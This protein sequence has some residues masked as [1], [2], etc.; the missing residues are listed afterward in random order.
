[1]IPDLTVLWVV[2]FVLTLAGVVKRLL[3][4][5]VLRVMRERDRVVASAR[6]LAE[7]AAGKAESATAEAS[8]TVRAARAEVY[9]QMDEKR[10]LALT[11][12][13]E[14]LDAARRDAEAGIGEARS[15]LEAQAERARHQLTEQADALGAAAVE[16]ILGRKTS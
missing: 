9:R 11:Q 5:P 12:H 2:L 10:R 15:R 1:M 7:S 14:V 3:F 6:E 8:E 16:R 13:A 4:D